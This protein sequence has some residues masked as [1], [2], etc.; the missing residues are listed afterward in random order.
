MMKTDRGYLLVVVGILTRTYFECG[1]SR[2]SDR[3]NNRSLE[4]ME[5]EIGVKNGYNRIPETNHKYQS[6]HQ[7][8]R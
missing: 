8:S 1:I 3:C 5:I 6:I 4:I 2:A 7:Q